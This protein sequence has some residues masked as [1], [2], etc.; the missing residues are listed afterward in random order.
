MDRVSQPYDGEI[1]DF[2]IQS[3]IQFG[4]FLAMFDYQRAIILLNQSDEDWL[5]HTYP[6]R[7][8]VPFHGFTIYPTEN[9][10]DNKE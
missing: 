2:P 5:D 8:S 6:L 9:K 7:F 4:D 10:P 1:G 3:S